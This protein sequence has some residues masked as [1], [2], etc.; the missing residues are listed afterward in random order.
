MLKQMLLL[1]LWSK[2]SSVPLTSD[3]QR[4]SGR[5]VSNSESDGSRVSC[6]DTSKCE[7]V[8]PPLGSDQ[9]HFIILQRDVLEFPLD[10]RLLVGKLTLKADVFAL[11]YDAALQEL[12]YADLSSCLT[13]SFQQ[14]ENNEVARISTELPL[15]KPSKKGSSGLAFVKNNKRKDGIQVFK[16]SVEVGEQEVLLGGSQHKKGVLI[17]EVQFKRN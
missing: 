9:I 4:S 10:L 5:V 15:R 3:S 2:T 7:A 1:I 13:E 17:I 16:L 14:H 6:C 12:Q 11:A 8:R